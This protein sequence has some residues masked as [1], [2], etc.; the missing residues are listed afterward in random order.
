MHL[1]FV[2]VFNQVLDL[3]LIPIKF[4]LAI[5]A[6]DTNLNSDSLSI[7]YLI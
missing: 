2:S 3:T 6:V 5:Q 1:V 7:N 4:Y